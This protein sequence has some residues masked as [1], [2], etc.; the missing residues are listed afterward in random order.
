MTI[1]IE[2]YGENE[3]CAVARLREACEYVERVKGEEQKSVLRPFF[4]KSS[5]KL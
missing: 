1:N 3:D 5:D 4:F 2:I